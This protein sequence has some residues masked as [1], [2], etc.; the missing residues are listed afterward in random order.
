MTSAELG[1][2]EKSPQHSLPP[3][4]APRRSEA[5]EVRHGSAASLAE[6]N[7]TLIGTIAVAEAT[8]EALA[9]QGAC[10]RDCVPRRHSAVSLSLPSFFPCV[11]SWSWASAGG[12]GRRLR[13]RVAGS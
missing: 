10:G 9:E 2:R 4:S 13:G 12:A 3:M 11:F 8:L 6:A 5:A 7:R 1:N